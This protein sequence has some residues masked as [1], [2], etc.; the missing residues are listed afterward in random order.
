MNIERRLTRLESYRLVNP[1]Q[2]LNICIFGVDNTEPGAY[3]C[4]DTVITRRADESIAEFKARC[5]E[6][7]V[8]DSIHLSFFKRLEGSDSEKRIDALEN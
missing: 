5:V 6:S 8:T 7:V 1:N 4:G 3:K 2:P